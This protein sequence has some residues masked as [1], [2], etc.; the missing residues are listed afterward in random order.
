MWSSAHNGHRQGFTDLVINSKGSSHMN[1]MEK[2]LGSMHIP[3]VKGVSEK[4]NI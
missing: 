3:Y 1:N 4:F 2:P